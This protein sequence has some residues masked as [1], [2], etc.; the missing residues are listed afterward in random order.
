MVRRAEH[1]VGA[2]VD[3]LT[4]K[5]RQALE[6]VATNHTTKEMAHALGISE[7]AAIKRVLALREKF[8][9]IT[10]NQ[11]ARK[12]QKFKQTSAQTYQKSIPSDDHHGKKFHLLQSSPDE[13]NCDGQH[14]DSTVEFSDAIQTRIDVPWASYDEPPVVPGA[15]DREGSGVLRI[16]AAV[17]VALGVAVLAL[18]IIGVS[19]A[20]EDLL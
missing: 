7:P 2:I 12:Y 4:P 8:G 9:G 20:V 19:A 17:L 16:A 18:V 1:S 3:S 14:A 15:L 11:L 10:K 13:E 5:Q 6:L